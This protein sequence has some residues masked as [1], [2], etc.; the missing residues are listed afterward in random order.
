MIENFGTLEMQRAVWRRARQPLRLLDPDSDDFATGG[1]ARHIPDLSVRGLVLPGDPEAE[2]LEFD[3]E[4]WGWWLTNWPNP[5][6]RSTTAWGSASHP[7]AQAAVRHDQPSDDPWKWDVYVALHR[8]GGLE[9]GLGRA[10][11]S[12]ANDRRIFLLIPIIGRVW[13]ALHLY[14]EVV[15]RFNLKGPWELS[16]ALRRTGGAQLGG[17]GEGWLEPWDFRGGDTLPTC[18]E[19]NLPTAAR[20]RCLAGPTDHRAS[21]SQSGS[22]D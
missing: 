3:E 2:A 5:F 10:V 12:K 8:H 1:L 4:L 11:T 16:V 18:P 14:R 13:A 21:G 22:I 17:L 19:P 6:N 7:T 15:N 9:F 20:D